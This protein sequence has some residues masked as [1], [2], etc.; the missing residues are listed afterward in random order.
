[1]AFRKQTFFFLNEGKRSKE[2]GEPFWKV[3]NG[4]GTENQ[5]KLRL[6]ARTKEVNERILL[7][8]RRE[9]WRIGVIGRT[10]AML[11]RPYTSLFNFTSRTFKRYSPRLT[12]EF[13]LFS[14]MFQ[15]S[16]LYYLA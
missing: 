16:R 14:E 2:H 6:R 9:M 4:E 8:R 11:R 3:H 15:L 12:L 10:L 7:L 5:S 1:M 13:P